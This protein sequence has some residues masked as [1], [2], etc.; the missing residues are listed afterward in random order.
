M[1]SLRISLRTKLALI[2]LLLLALPWVG[3]RYVDEM[4]RFLRD[5]QRDAL[6]ATARAVATALATGARPDGWVCQMAGQR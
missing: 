3:Y 1:T 4:E 6:V 2:S 5:G